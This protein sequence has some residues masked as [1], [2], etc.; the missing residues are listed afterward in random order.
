MEM[1]VTNSVHLDGVGIIT[2]VSFIHLVN[3]NSVCSQLPG[4]RESSYDIVHLLAIFV[5]RK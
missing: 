2:G 5:D 4:K 1:L 3:R